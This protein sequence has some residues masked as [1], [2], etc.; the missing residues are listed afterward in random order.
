[1]GTGRTVGEAGRPVYRIVAVVGQDKGRA[2][3]ATL[4]EIAAQL[5]TAELSFLV[6]GASLHRQIGQLVITDDLTR[7][8][9][10]NMRDLHPRIMVGITAII[11]TKQAYYHEYDAKYPCSTPRQPTM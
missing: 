5:G 8:Y 6:G 9:G 2:A 10:H 4:T 1:M 7:S 3:H 11:P